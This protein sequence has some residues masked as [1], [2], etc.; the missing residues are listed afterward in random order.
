MV[1][2]FMLFRLNVI[3]K[4]L[5]V[6]RS[7]NAIMVNVIVVHGSFGHPGENWFPWLKAELEALDC[8]VH[9]PRFPTPEGQS[10]NSWLAAFEPFQPYLKEDTILVGHSIGPAFLLSVLEQSQHRVDSAF[11]V[12]GFVGPLCNPEFDKINASF[13]ERDF[14]WE[15]IRE[16]CGSFYVISSKDDPYV[17]LEKGQELA[18]AVGGMLFTIPKAGHFNTAAGYGK[19]PMLLEMIKGRLKQ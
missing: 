19:F 5:N 1:A 11:F 17:P 7:S 6:Q 8:T 3:Q 13:A 12:A 10:L 2:R 4:V 18:D 15:R 14:D 9:V 16:N